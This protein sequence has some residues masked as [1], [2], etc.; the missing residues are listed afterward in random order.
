M[1]VPGGTTAEIG[2]RLL[3]PLEKAIAL[4]VLFVFALDVFLQRVGRAEIIDDHRMVDHQIDRHQRVDLVGIAAKRLHRVAHR[5]QIDHRRHAGEVL[6]QHAGRAKGDFML[7]LAAVLHPGGDRLDVGLG[8]RAAVLVA[9]Q[10]LQHNLERE[11]QLRNGGETVPLGGFQRVIVIGLGPHR[12]RLATFEAVKAGHRRGSAISREGKRGNERAYRYICTAGI[13]KLKTVR[14][15]N[16]GAAE[17]KSMRLAAENVAIER[18]GRLVIAGLSFEARSG[19]PLLLVGPNGSGKSTLLRAIAGLLPLTGGALTLEGG[20]ADASIGEQAHLLGHADGL[21]GA[22]TAHRKGLAFWA[23]TLGGGSGS[24]A[25]QAPSDA[26]RRLGLSHIA[27]FPVRALSAGQ[28]RRV[29][30]ARL[31]VA[32]RPIWLLDE[33]TSA[34]DAAAQALFADVMRE[35]LSTGGVI[36]AATHG[37]IGLDGAAHLTLGPLFGAGVAP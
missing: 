7:V 6:H 19:A 4:E 10:V 22:L 35:H 1:P 36:L 12:E 17:G 11:G 9:Q 26:L 34:L 18:G 27:D 24:P 29:A 30:L 15:Q 2:E 3:A 31:V 33:P 16:E 28:K 13:D 37:P 14:A 25:A 20:A 23:A 21:K 32:R 5:R 8:H